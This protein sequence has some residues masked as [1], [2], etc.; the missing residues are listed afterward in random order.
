M[1]RISSLL[2]SPK[3]AERHPLEIFAIVIIY[4]SVSIFLSLWILPNHASLAMVFL[5]IIS[6]LY[7][8]QS[9]LIVEETKESSYKSESWILKEHAKTLWFFMII[10]FGFLAAYIFWMLVLPNSMTSQIFEIQSSTFEEIRS[11]TGRVTSPEAFSIILSNNL[12]VL[13]LSMILALFYGA[14]SLFILAWNASLM[15]YIIGNLV[16][17]SLGLIS[18]PYAFLKFFIHGIPEIMAYFTAALAGSILFIAVIRGDLKK[19]KLK[20]TLLDVT[21]ITITSVGLLILA[22]A[23]ETYISP[24][25]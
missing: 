16:R 14:G 1:A 19:D 20:K 4:T 6:C 22:A 8:V 3:K 12:R 23:I 9:T 13:L 7:L 2:F 11:I 21:I 5:S 17:N 15:G 18:L 24:I 25:L 10:F